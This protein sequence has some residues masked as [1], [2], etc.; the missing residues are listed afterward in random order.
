MTELKLTE[1]TA[2]H[3]QT[4]LDANGIIGP[5]GKSVDVTT[6][7]S[8]T[9]NDKQLTVVFDTGYSLPQVP[10][11]VAHSMSALARIDTCGCSS[12]AEAFYQNV[13]GA[14]YIDN[15]ASLAGPAWQIPCDD[16]INVTFKFGGQ[17][18]PINPLDVSLDLGAED[19]SG[20]AICYGGV[21]T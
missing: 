12:V 13:P 2:Q 1:Q 6:G 10:R 3:W 19:S 8:S 21:R 14:Q 9:S 11:Y 15:V 18:Y 7:V 16:E 17:S 4:L 5:N 20:N